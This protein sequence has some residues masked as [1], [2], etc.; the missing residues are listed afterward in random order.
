LE[1]RHEPSLVLG[2]LSLGLVAVET[3]DVG[4]EEEVVARLFDGDLRFRAYA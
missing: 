2:V 1:A 3:K 4:P